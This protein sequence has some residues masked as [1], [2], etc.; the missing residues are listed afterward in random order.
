[1]GDGEYDHVNTYAKFYGD[2]IKVYW[3]IHMS[4]INKNNNIL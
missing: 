2:N 4:S 1:M 3:N